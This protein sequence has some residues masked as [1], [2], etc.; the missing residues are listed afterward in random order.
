[1]FTSEDT[2]RSEV[3]AG[4]NRRRQRSELRPH[5]KEEAMSYALA[6]VLRDGHRP[7]ATPGRRA[8]TETSTGLGV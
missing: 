8:G 6:T 2:C 7:S 3:A 4:A 5:P 1:M